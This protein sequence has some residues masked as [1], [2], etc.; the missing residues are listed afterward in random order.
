MKKKY[1]EIIIQSQEKEI[2]EIQEF[3]EHICDKY[4]IHNYLGLLSVAVIEAVENAIKHGN[5]LDPKKKV[6]IKCSKTHEGICI[7]VEDEGKGFDYRKYNSLSEK[8]GKGE[9][10]YLMKALSNRLSFL[11][12]GRIVELMFFIDGIESTRTLERASFMQKY[13]E[14]QQAHVEKRQRA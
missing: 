2:I 14:K 1:E 7:R 4:N 6:K 8:T 5:Q 10:I 13:F 11:A 3:I 9:G 12:K